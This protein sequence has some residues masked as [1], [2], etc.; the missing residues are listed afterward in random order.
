MLSIAITI[1]NLIAVTL[2]LLTAWNM[3]KTDKLSEAWQRDMR[4]AQAVLL[5]HIDNMSEFMSNLPTL[6]KGSLY[7]V[8]LI[9]RSTEL[10]ETFQDICGYTSI[11]DERLQNEEGKDSENESSDEQG[12][13]A[14]SGGCSS[15][16]CA[17]HQDDCHTC[18]CHENTEADRVSPAVTSN[19][20]H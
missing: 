19:E 1:I 13:E 18:H 2:L 9:E 15:A 3:H 11:A 14:A 4:H 8:A 6:G 7:G 17:R 16:A 12:A 20:Q 10:I 5:E